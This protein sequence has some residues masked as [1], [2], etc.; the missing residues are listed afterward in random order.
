MKQMNVVLLLSLILSLSHA[1]RYGVRRRWISNANNCT[2]TPAGIEY[3]PLGS[4]FR[5]P[6]SGT[7]YPRTS[8]LFIYPLSFY[9]LLSPLD[10]LLPFFLPLFLFKIN[11]I[12]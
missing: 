11:Y 1:A 5:E 2:D 6:G 8:Y 7:H 9:H 4:P 10:L 12:N 3:W